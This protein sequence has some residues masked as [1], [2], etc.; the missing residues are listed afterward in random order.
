MTRRTFI[1][2]VVSLLFNML[3]RLVITFLPRS[4]RLL[5][6]WLQS[7]SAVILEPPKIKS[8][9]VS[10]IS[11]TSCGYDNLIG[12]HMCTRPSPLPHLACPR[13]G[14]EA[15]DLM[16]RGEARVSA[17]QPSRAQPAPRG[18]GQT[19][20]SLL[21]SYWV[22]TI[23]RRAYAQLKPLPVATAGPRGVAPR[24]P[25]ALT[26]QMRHLRVLRMPAPTS[27]PVQG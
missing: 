8:L 17:V 24:W 5:I 3:S 23:L 15:C 26:R 16:E 19:L 18:D 27:V 2:K 9:T 4:K 7:P 11:P 25:Q 14:T 1:T 20:T 12:C 13:R 21:D 6:L 10:I 22:W